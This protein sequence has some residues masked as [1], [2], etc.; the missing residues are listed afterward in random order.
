M[1]KTFSARFDDA[2]KDEGPWIERVVG[3]TRAEPHFVWPT[4]E[5]MYEELGRLFEH[6]EEPFGSASVYAQWC[7]MRL[8]KE[9]GV[10]VLL[11]GQ[12]ADE[13]LAGYHE[14]FGVVAAD[15]FR[16][17]R[18]RDFA[19]WRGSYKALHGRP[20]GPLSWAVRGSVPEGLRRP[21]RRLLGRDGGAGVEPAA[22][23]YPPGFGKVSALKKIL[24]WHTT[25]QGLVEL[26]RYADR[27]SMAHSREVRLPFLDHRLV[28]FVFRLPDDQILR[29][30]W[31]KWVMRRAFRGVV[32]G[33]ILDRVDKL[34][35]APPQERWLGG[36][37]WKELML[38]ELEKR[39][40]GL[41]GGAEA[42]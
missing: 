7:V 4:G 6:Q 9:Q 17:M 19:A 28:E 42:A 31:T 34:G 40:G 24:W 32:P 23:E 3:A 8:A 1:Q 13:M 39:D 12:G 15:L 27:N 20:L 37:G 38:A 16:G 14:Y 10:T 36:R 22:P 30:G 11:D 5:R 2:A 25:R 41:A 26:L 35:Y 29:G 33:P 21:V 18:L